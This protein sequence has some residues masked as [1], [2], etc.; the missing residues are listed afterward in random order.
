MPSVNLTEITVRS[1]KATDRRTTYWDAG[2]PNFGVRVGARRKTFIVLVGDERQRVTLGHHGEM[3][4]A[5]AR[6]A[7]RAQLAAREQ[8]GKRSQRLEP[9]TFKAALEMFLETY[10]KQN[11]G[12]RMAHE[13]KRL[14][15]THFLDE[16]EDDNLAAIETGA[17]AKILDGLHNTPSEAEHAFRIVRTFFNFGVKRKF[18][19]TSPI[20]DLEPPP[21]GPER[22]RVLTDEELAKVWRKAAS[23]GHPYGTIVQLLVLCGQRTGETA[24]LRWKW[25]DDESINLPA[26]ITKNSRPSRIPYGSLTKQILGVVPKKSDLLF[27]ARGHDDKPFRGFGVSKLVLDECGVSSYTHHDLRRTYS[28]NMARLRVPIHVTEKLLN[29]STGVLRGVA[30]IYNR[31]TYWEEMVE[32]VSSYEQWLQTTVSKV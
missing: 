32:A 19:T 30:R 29:H 16:F 12:P 24:A 7:A 18:L 10:S 14:L 9:I 8:E 15:E 1:L 4:L 6:K 23:I 5:D 3:T 26:Y 25:I 31:H 17:I 11:H 20:A 13:A 22:D 28:T 2:M 27:P 21:K